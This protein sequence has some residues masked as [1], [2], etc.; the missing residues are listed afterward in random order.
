MTPAPLPRIIALARAGA[1]EL[2]WALFRE[3][4][5]EVSADPAAL[6][7]KGRLLKDRALQAPGAERQRLLGEAAAAYSAA[8]GAAPEPY[9][10]INVASLSLLASNVA[11]AEAAAR[12]VLTRLASPVPETP[13]YIAATRAEAALILGDQAGAAAAMAEAIAHDPD[14][15]SDH[16]STLRQLA[17]ISTHRGGVADWLDPFRPPRALHFAGHLGIAHGGAGEASLHDELA[18]FLDEERIG[19]AWGALAAGSDI[20][21]AEALIARGIALNLV[22]PCPADCFRA[23]SVAPLGEAWG[24]RFD[25]LRKAAEG[26]AAA[27]QL[28]GPHEPLATALASEIAMGAAARQAAL[29]ETEALQLL[30]VDG[31]GGG[32]NT[33]RQGTVWGASGR[34]QHRIVI[35]RDGALPETTLRPDRVHPT[36]RLAA[37]LAIELGGVE[38]LEEGKLS[39]LVDEVCASVVAVLAGRPLTTLGGGGTAWL[40]GHDDC[41][42]AVETALAVRAALVGADLEANGLTLRVAAHYA[43][44]NAVADAAARLPVLIGG[45]VDRVRTLPLVSPP[46]AIVATEPF[47]N[48]LFARGSELVRAQPM[49]DVAIPPDGRIETLFALTPR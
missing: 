18:H 15:W 40:A 10:L 41:G 3:G 29:L 46:G 48:A 34:R 25:A 8:D 9:L 13:Y 33:S 23:H 43:L 27:T 14:G 12:T 32:A 17:L 38:A 47:A 49:G 7:V 44:V 6:A 1:L 11:G 28:S 42:A 19:F 36:R 16:A 22:L 37:M 39:W 24:R 30:I 21:I 20:V 35:P 5:Y 45:A 2:A 26:I 31:E 4:G